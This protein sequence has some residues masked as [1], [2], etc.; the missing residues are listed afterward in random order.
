MSSD[1]LWMLV[2]KHNSFMRR[3]DGVTLSAD[4]GNV[5]NE[6]SFKASGV[7]NRRT[8]DLRVVTSKDGK[9]RRVQL[10]TKRARGQRKP[11]TAL[12]T[13]VLSKHRNNGA[14]KGARAV[15]AATK[16]NHYRAD[17]A[18]D[19]VARYHKLRKSTLKRTINRRVRTRSTKKSE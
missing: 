4:S 1:L 8:V 10:S 18:D 9:D 17:L 3:S 13:S 12:S 11:A 14:I 2:R 5:T 16:G 6:H 19:A 15:R 7:A